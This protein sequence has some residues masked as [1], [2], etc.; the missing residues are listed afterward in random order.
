METLFL[1]G[2]NGDIGKAILPMLARKYHVRALIRSGTPAKIENVTWIHGDLNNPSSYEK[3]LK[4]VRVLVHLAALLRSGNIE[5]LHL[6]NVENTL[7]LVGAA[8][9]S[10]CSTMIIFSTAAITHTVLTPYAQ[11]KKKMEDELMRMNIPLYI[12]R[13]TLV[14]GKDS[15][16]LKLF[17]QWVNGKSPVIFLPNQGNAVLSPVYTDDIGVGILALAK[18]KP[19][20]I[21]QYDFCPRDKTTLRQIVECVSAI[22][23]TPLKPVLSPPHE[24]VVGSIRFLQKASLPVPRALLGVGAAGSSYIVDSARFTRDFGVSFKSASE[25]IPMILRGKN[26]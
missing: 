6:E 25:V 12:V 10:G 18:K 5:K 17:K 13:P 14:Y 26:E 21:Q 8:R 22:E 7:K 4:G 24:L 20:R 2:A 23:G 9:A 15:Y 11:S 1:T 19:T 3:N 16:Y